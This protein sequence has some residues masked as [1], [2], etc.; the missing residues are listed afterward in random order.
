MEDSANRV[1]LS[2][3]TNKHHCLVGHVNSQDAMP[4][5]LPPKML[6]SKLAT[7]GPAPK[8][9]SEDIGFATLDPS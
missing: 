5:K 7:Q 4:P 1:L 3:R 8:Q 2:N 6:R 9:L